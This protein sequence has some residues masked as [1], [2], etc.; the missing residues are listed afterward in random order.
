MSIRSNRWS[1]IKATR[2]IILLRRLQKFLC[3]IDLFDEVFVL[4]VDLDTLNRRLAGR[5]EDEF[6][7]KPGE[8]ELIARLHSTKEDVPKGDV[9]IDA[10][11]PIE[12]VV[13][14][15]LERCS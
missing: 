7:G 4:D 6:G 2:C 3:F 11:A 12:R 13:D 14:E 10:T 8:R 15:I 5:A 1:L 9:V